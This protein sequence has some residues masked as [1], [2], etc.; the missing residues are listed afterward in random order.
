MAS[1][2]VAVREADLPARRSAVILA[3]GMVASALIAAVWFPLLLR[4]FWLDEAGTYFVAHKGWRFAFGQSLRSPGQSILYGVLTSL[5]CVTSGP[6]KELSL[7]FPS[8]L[9]VA[10][11]AYL[12]YRFAERML[13]KGAGIV[14][15][16]VFL[17]DPQVIRSGAN[18]RP[19]A[20]AMCT[21]VGCCWAF[22][23]WQQTASRRALA[24]FV[25]CSAGV[26]YLHYLFVVILIVPAAFAAYGVARGRHPQW[27]W[28]A[29]AFGAIVIAAIPLAQHM[30]LLAAQ[31]SALSF[32]AHPTFKDLLDVLAPLPLVL[33]AA[34][35]ARLVLVPGPGRGPRPGLPEEALVY[36]ILWWAAVPLI[37]FL[38]AVWS[39]YAVFVTRYVSSA[40][41]AISLL[42]AGLAALTFSVSG[43]KKFSLAVVAVMCIRPETVWSYRHIGHMELRPALDLV[44]RLSP[45]S[46]TPLIVTSGLAESNLQD[47]EG[48]T[49]ACPHL[50]APLIAYPVSNPLYLLPWRLD[51]RAR[52]FVKRKVE[53]ELRLANTILLLSTTSG[54]TIPWVRSYLQSHGYDGE[55]REVN[56]YAVAI[57]R[58]RNGPSMLSAV[59]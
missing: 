10:V 2:P 52:A 31:S 49:K 18:A 4:S 30:R 27:P 11:A 58:K 28:T 13:G 5:F 54:E 15:L 50:A 19:Y 41:P 37:F 35:S 38:L 59:Q 24:L 29:V 7:R 33:A 34:C 47:W 55:I 23:E 44:Q 14:A 36:I 39:P 42:V 56:Y 25:L 12:L 1:A 53:G 32:A 40:R 26:V 9:G 43:R 22:W 57:F 3:C 6:L 17:T 8:L 48:G 21:V 51:D 46:T 16:S 45:G 20:L